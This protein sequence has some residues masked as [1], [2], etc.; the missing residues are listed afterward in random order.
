MSGAPAQADT[1]A[2]TARLGRRR[3]LLVGGAAGLA[4]ALIAGVLVVV[5]LVGRASTPTWRT[6]FEDNFSTGSV[7]P[8]SWNVR[9]E[10]YNPNERSILTDRPENVRVTDGVLNIQAHREKRTVGKTTR[11]YT[12]GYLDTIGKHS[13]RYGRF[14]VRAK[15]PLSQGLWPAFWLRSDTGPG[16]IDIM[17]AIGGLPDLAQQTVL[18][19]TMGDKAQSVHRQTLSTS[20]ANWHV[21]AV[22]VEPDS[23]KWMIDGRQVFEA[24]TSKLA[25]LH[26]VVA[27][28]LNIRLN[29][30]VGGVLPDYYHHPVTNS[31]VL[32]ATYAVDWVRVSQRS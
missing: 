13:W 27:G 7:D 10:T 6:A 26:N 11:Q 28:P 15:L 16:E 19:S 2:P 24:T 32:P 30:Q 8:D 9:N 17:E 25:W 4:V 22:E 21:Y 18:E 23:I 1:P 14:E 31:S 3:R 5:H 29:L 12:S 20:I